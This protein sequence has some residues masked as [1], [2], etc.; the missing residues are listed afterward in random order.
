MCH[1]GCSIRRHRLVMMTFLVTG[2]RSPIAGAVCRALA[3]SGHKVILVT[4]SADSDFS[5]S[6]DTFGAVELLE[7][8]LATSDGL[9][10]VVCAVKRVS[11]FSGAIFA[12]RYR[13]PEDSA[14]QLN[15]EVLG[16]VRIV[17]EACEARLS[18]ELAFV[19]LTSPAA[20]S[21]VDDAPIGYH[22]AKSSMNSAVR[23]LANRFGADGVR[24]NAVSPGAFVE[25]ERSRQF[26]DQNPDRVQWAVGA[27]PLG[28]FAHPDEI[29]SVVTFLTSKESSYVTGQVIEVD[30]G[31]LLRDLA[32]F[33]QPVTERNFHS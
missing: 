3:T 20:R 19:F 25:K 21:V 33:R 14:V 22:L 17:V 9:E 7:A 2:G 32:S 27:T 6:W 18:R 13:G 26:F 4:R 29:A 31:L 1:A 12:H 28:R 15:L 30:G 24:V 11:D 23:F 8:D 16:P 5:A 10:R